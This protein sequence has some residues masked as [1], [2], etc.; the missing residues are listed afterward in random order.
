MATSNVTNS[1]TAGSELDGV[2][3]IARLKPGGGFKVDTAAEV[4]AYAETTFSSGSWTLALEQQAN[5]TPDGSYWEIEEQIPAANGGPRVWAVS[6]GA[7]NSTLQAARITPSLSPSLANYLTQEAADARYA[8]IGSGSTDLNVINVKD[9]GAVGDGTTDDTSALNLAK[10]A[11]ASTGGKFVMP[12]GTYITDGGINFSGI[13]DLAIEGYGATLKRKANSLGALSVE[14]LINLN[15]CDRVRIVGIHF[16]GN[17]SNQGAT[18]SEFNHGIGISTVSPNTACNIVGIAD[19]S[20]TGNAGDAITV[21]GASAHVWIERCYI[22]DPKPSGGGSNARQ[23]VAVTQGGD[24][25]IV[26]NTFDGDG[27]LRVGC[28]AVDIESDG[29]SI[30]DGV[31]VIGN[32]ANDAM[33]NRFVHVANN[34]GGSMGSVV[35]ADNTSRRYISLVADTGTRG[36]EVQVLGNTI[37]ENVRCVNFNRV[38]ISDNSFRGRDADS[39]EN[40]L[41]YVENAAVGAVISDNNL[42][43]SGGAQIT[44]G[45]IHLVGANTHI[46]VTG[47]AIS[48]LTNGASVREGVV[49]DSDGSN[50]PSHINIGENIF[51]TT[52]DAMANAVKLASMDASSQRYISIGHNLVGAGVT[53]LVDDI[54]KVFAMPGYFTASTT[55]GATL[56]V[57]HGTAPTSPVNGDIWTTTAGIY[58]RVNGATVGPL[59]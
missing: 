31:Y 3:V 51:R 8:A 24:V 4:D 20:F 49:I 26:N 47:N 16:D 56:R 59:S 41:I 27:S 17:R 44:E 34:G 57:P 54:S 40:A 12:P 11:I 32:R 50:H 21:A 10:A 18:Y 22:T 6:V 37:T 45:A 43:S 53:T 55:G 42:S 7:S 39:L 29:S 2:A 30:I 9:Y 19:C 36:E 28:I 14:P 52:G 1:H 25:W 15:D 33:W 46:D 35:I 5:I 48:S 58:V 38:T 13:T 23:G